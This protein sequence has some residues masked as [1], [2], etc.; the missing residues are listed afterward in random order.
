[1]AVPAPS[2]RLFWRLWSASTASNLAD[3]IRSAAF[4]LLAAAISR[5][6]LA[7]ALVA[8]AQ[9]LPWLFLGL[10]S[11]VVA[12]RVDGRR[13]I[14]RVNAVRTVL[15]V[16]LLGAILTGATTMVLL[17]VVAFAL[18]SA[19]AIVDSAYP[20]LVVAAVGDDR[21]EWAN[22]R[23]VAGSVAGNELVG[24]AIG[25][26][27]FAIGLALPIAV[28]SGLVAAS[29]MFILSLPILTVSKA[30]A[31][32]ARKGPGQIREGVRWLLA[33]QGL[34][35]VTVAG[36]VLALLDSAWYAVLVL[37]V[38]DELNLVEAGF[39]ALLAVAALGGLA[40]SVVAER[41]SRRFSVGARLAASVIV[42]GMTQFVVGLSSGVVVVGLMLAIS[43]GAFAVWNV[44]AATLRQRVV[45]KGMLGRVTATYT[46]ALVGSAAAGA[47]LGGL[48][49]SAAGLRAPMLI[50]GPI[51]IA[52]GVWL[53]AVLRRELQ[54][55]S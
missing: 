29:A 54:Q 6:P 19:E 32:S 44:T 1:M 41:V 22:A 50:G 27:L 5:D 14:W 15:L 35:A 28:D 17:L 33:H 45:A 21:L 16:G 48:L 42:A 26:W 24:P 3:G 38:L 23:L 2:P 18:G 12:D 46:T 55:A 53:R 8:V 40:G 36:A 25:S 20:G 47:V 51:L 30:D 9:Q 34:T 49:A 7:V 39:G 31:P 10:W 4:P 13:L 43:S 11:G 37:F 52:T